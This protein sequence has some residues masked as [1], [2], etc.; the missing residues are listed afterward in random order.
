MLDMEIGA[1]LQTDV[2]FEAA[3]T[4]YSVGGNRLEASPVTIREHAAGPLGARK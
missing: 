1:D 3:Y 2:G 4:A